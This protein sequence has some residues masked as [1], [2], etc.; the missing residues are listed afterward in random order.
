MA[1]AFVGTSGWSYDNWV[2]PFYPEKLPRNQWLTHYAQHLGTVELNASFY[3]LPM[4]NMLKGWVKRTPEDFR[5]SVKAWQQLTHRKRLKDCGD[6]IRVFFER[7]EPLADR[8]AAVLFQLPPKM[9]LDT[10]RLEGFLQQLPAGTRAAFEFRDPRWHVRPIY[11]V[12]EHHNAAFVPF[13]LADE[14]APAVATADFVYL[15]LHGRNAK[16]RGRYGHAQL[17]PWADWLKEQ[18]H[19]GRDAFVFFDNTDQQDDAVRDALEM[20]KMLST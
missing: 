4:G 10:E 19:A 18:M 15:R 13:E 8:T 12:L 5:F 17:I 6:Q 2:G 7:M 3:R 16:Y 9:P 14:R 20:R 11:D 1:R